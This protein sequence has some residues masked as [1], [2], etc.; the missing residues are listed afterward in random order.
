M[1]N[2]KIYGLENVADGAKRGRFSIQ[3][4]PNGHWVRDAIRIDVSRDIM[5]EGWSVGVKYS[6]A[7][8]GGKSGVNEDDALDNFIEALQFA[9]T[10]SKTFNPE[11]LEAYWQIGIKQFNKSQKEVA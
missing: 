2:F 6:G 9:R 8:D 5:G 3:I 1:N 7:P 10:L 4:Q 11:V